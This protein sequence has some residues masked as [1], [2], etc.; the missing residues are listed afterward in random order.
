MIF[1]SS[2]WS[3]YLSIYL[4]FLGLPPVPTYDVYGRAQPDTL[5]VWAIQTSIAFFCCWAIRRLEVSQHAC[6]VPYRA[7]CWCHSFPACFLQLVF[8]ALCFFL[9]AIVRRRDGCRVDWSVRNSR[10]T[11]AWH[12]DNKA[13]IFGSSTFFLLLGVQCYHWTRNRSAS[14]A[15]AS[16]QIIPVSY[17]CFRK[18]HVLMYVRTGYEYVV[19]LRKRNADRSYTIAICCKKQEYCCDPN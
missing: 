9:Y 15:T 14:S 7:Y 11:Q 17:C 18:C 3:I 12:R 2:V 13:S 19:I 16:T 1:L 4:Y 6:F 5:I 10:E 8:T